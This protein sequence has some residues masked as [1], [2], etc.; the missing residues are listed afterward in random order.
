MVYF[1]SEKGLLLDNLQMKRKVQITAYL[2]D[3]HA[4]TESLSP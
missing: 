3:K 2:R 4:D 1:Y